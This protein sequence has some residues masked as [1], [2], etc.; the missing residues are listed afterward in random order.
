VVATIK[1][2]TTLAATI[3]M[4]TTIVATIMAFIVNTIHRISHRAIIKHKP[5]LSKDDWLFTTQILAQPAGCKTTQDRAFGMINS[6][7]L[8]DQIPIF[9]KM[10]LL[11][12]TPMVRYNSALQ[13]PEQHFGNT[14]VLSFQPTP[15]TAGKICIL[16][17]Q[18]DKVVQ[19]YHLAFDH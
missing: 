8:Q 11:I 9:N 1:D 17:Q 10:V 16:T 7:H 2:H 19:W 5:I 15:A 3:T 4:A 12:N 6:N 14:R 13:Y 18:L